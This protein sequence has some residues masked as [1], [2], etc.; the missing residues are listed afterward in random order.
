MDVT[1]IYKET[2]NISTRGRAADGID[3]LGI[4]AYLTVHIL[5]GFH[6]GA[7]I[8]SECSSTITIKG[9][10]FDMKGLRTRAKFERQR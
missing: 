2:C 8:L 6:V 4:T 10:V 3:T 9:E 1:I 7:S 5:N